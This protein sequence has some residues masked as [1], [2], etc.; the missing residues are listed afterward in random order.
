MREALGRW[1]KRITG[2]EVDAARGDD[3]AMVILTLRYAHAIT[4]RRDTLL[5]PLL[6]R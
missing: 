3:P 1:E 5:Y 4:G 6:L 2:V